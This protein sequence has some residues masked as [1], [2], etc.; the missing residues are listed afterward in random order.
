MNCARRVLVVVVACVI[1]VAL[2]GSDCDNNRQVSMSGAK[3]I[4]DVVRI[5][6][7]SRGHTSEQ[8]NIADRTNILNDPAKVL[9]AHLI[10]LDGNLIKRF[11]VRCK[12]TSSGKR[13]EP[14]TAAQYGP[15][16]RIKQADGSYQDYSTAE[17]LQPDGTF[18]ESDKYEFWFDPMGR[19]H[20]IGTAGGIG[21]L[22]TDYP[23]DI[24]NPID[25]I[26]GLYRMQE[27]AHQW[28]LQQEEQLRQRE[29]TLRTIPKAE[30][31]KGLE[32]KQGS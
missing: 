1:G 10:S 29:E 24:E 12:M 19:Y 9:W 26:T 7:N 11:P 13:L 31:E 17:F 28:Q 4:T 23:I 14:R 3:Q 30:Q 32:Q 2:M 6:L 5:P 18:G 16:Y 22:L 15:T 20:Q 21:Y 8:Q 25:K 27:A